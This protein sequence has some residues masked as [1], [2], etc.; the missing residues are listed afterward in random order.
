MLALIRKPEDLPPVQTSE[1][2]RP[3]PKKI[4]FLGYSILATHIKFGMLGLY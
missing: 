2:E 3:L 1:I 4:V